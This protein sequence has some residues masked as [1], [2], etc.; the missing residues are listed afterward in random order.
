MFLG[1]WA[2]AYNEHGDLVQ[3]YQGMGARIGRLTVS[4]PRR[5]L[6]KPDRQSSLEIL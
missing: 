5:V 6:A 3:A 2:L 1:S 4:Y